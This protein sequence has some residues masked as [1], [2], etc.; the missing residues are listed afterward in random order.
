MPVKFTRPRFV[1]TRE[2]PAPS[3]PWDAFKENVE[4]CP[5]VTFSRQARDATEHLE[6]ETRLQAFGRGSKADETYEDELNRLEPDDK[7]AMP[8]KVRYHKE[9]YRLNK[10]T[11]LQV[12]SKFGMITLRSCFYR[13]EQVGEPGVHPVR[14]RLGIGARLGDAGVVGTR[15]PRVG[16]SHPGR[17]ACLAVTRARPDLVQ[18]S[19]ACGA[20]GISPGMLP[21]V[22]GLQK[23][24]LLA[25]LKQAENSRGRHRP[26]LAA[27]R[28]GIMIP[29]RSGGYEEAS[30]AT[31]S[32]YD[33]RRRRLGTIYV[34]Q[35]PEAKT[36]DVERHVDAVNCAAT[37]EDWHGPLPRLAYITDKGSACDEYYHDV[38]KKMKHPRDGK[39]LALGVGARFLARVQFT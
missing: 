1:S 29:M 39:L 3:D 22:P 18:R 23:P 34:G 38:L 37:L 15:G 17:G 30:T 2:I 7:K 25:W 13:N 5:D 12:A 4:V 24:R 32:V 14:V 36:S 33:R 31:V 6:F 28:D 20:G 27:G 16:R 8:N 10:K 11:P 9:T 35:M 21:F 19:L 26:V